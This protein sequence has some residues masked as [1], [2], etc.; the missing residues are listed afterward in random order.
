M[1]LAVSPIFFGSALVSAFFASRGVAALDRSSL[2]GA[3]E[4]KTS[5]GAASES[6]D[7][8]NRSAARES[9]PRLM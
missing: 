3:S 2:S 5:S 9:V 1:S 4:P 6:I 8:T 7:D